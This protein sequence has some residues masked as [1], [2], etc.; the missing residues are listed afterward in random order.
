[1]EAHWDGSKPGDFHIFAWP[2]E[3]NEVNRFAISIPRGSS[4]DPHARSERAVSRPEERAADGAPAGRAGV[5][6]VPHHGRHRPPDDR[7]RAVRRLPVVARQARRPR[8]GTCR[9]C[10]TAGGSASSRCC[11]A[12]SPPRSD[13]SPGSR[14]AS[15]A[16]PT[17]SRRCTAASVLATLIL[18]VIVYGIVFAMGIYYINRLIARGPQGTA[19]EP[20][21]GAP[22]R[23]LVGRAGRGARSDAAGG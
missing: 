17:R 16:P 18:F 5:L 12:G 7:D 15:C 22:G 9:S 14:T 10:S 23:P 1:M 19:V 11:A 4:L 21:H 13:A 3:K 20:P 8:A 6:R 2:D